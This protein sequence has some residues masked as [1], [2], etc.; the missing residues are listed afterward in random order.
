MNAGITYIAYIALANCNL[1]K[2]MKLLITFL[3]G[4][5]VFSC[6]SSGD[7]SSVRKDQMNRLQEVAY[8]YKTFNK[9]DADFYQQNSFIDSAEKIDSA[10][11]RKLDSINWA[12]AIADC[13]SKNAKLPA[14]DFHM[15]LAEK[16]KSPHGNKLYKFYIK[17]VDAYFD[18]SVKQQPHG[19]V[20]VKETYNVAAVL[21]DTAI[22]RNFPMRKNLNDGKWYYPTTPSELFIMYKEDK[23]DEN[24]EGWVYGIV[25]IQNKKRSKVLFNGK[26]SSCIGCH[27]GTKYDRILSRK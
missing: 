13:T 11:K 23:N 20:L 15:S 1:L 3:I 12:W 9:I 8:D 22:R 2:F 6:V 16:G 17:N 19:Q 27:K 14:D 25:D 26:I 10:A 21:Q 18:T 4:S 7:V 5:L 24:D